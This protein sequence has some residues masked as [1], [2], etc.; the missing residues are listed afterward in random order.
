MNVG[1]FLTRAIFFR[2]KTMPFVVAAA[3]SSRESFFSAAPGPG[4]STSAGVSLA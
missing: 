2:L 1:G 3:G 4:E